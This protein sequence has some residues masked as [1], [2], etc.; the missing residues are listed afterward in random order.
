MGV[1][2]AGLVVMILAVAGMESSRDN[3]VERSLS[4]FEGDPP[5]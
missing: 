5:Q 1:A 3:E 4:V 2:L